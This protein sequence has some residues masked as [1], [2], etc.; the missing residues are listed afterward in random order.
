MMFIISLITLVVASLSAFVSVNCQEEV[1]KAAM[2]CLAVLCALITLLIAPW[3]IKLSLF[4][5]PLLVERE[6]FPLF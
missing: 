4:A 5:I 6:S 3:L 1:I 2:A